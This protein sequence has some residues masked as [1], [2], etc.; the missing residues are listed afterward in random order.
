MLPLLRLSV[1]VG[2]AWL[3]EQ[4]AAVAADYV[5]PAQFGAIARAALLLLLVVPMPLTARA[6]SQE[7]TNDTRVRA[8]VRAKA[9]I[10]QGSRVLVEH[11]AFDLLDQQWTFLIPAGNPG[12]VEAGAEMRGAPGHDR[13]SHGRRGKDV[14]DVG[15]VNPAML[16]TCR[17]TFAIL[18]HLVRYRAEKA[19]FRAELQ[20]YAALLQGAEGVARFSSIHGENG[21]PVVEIYR[22]RPLAPQPPAGHL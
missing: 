21:G 13:I 10:P 1:A 15:T 20:N 17:G 2:L 6:N 5:R 3:A 18:S 11:L 16:S 12:C 22:L 9:Y 8:S 4:I 7:R 14:V 19:L